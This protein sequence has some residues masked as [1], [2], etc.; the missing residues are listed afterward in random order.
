MNSQASQ[1]A[2]LRR[3]RR[4]CPYLTRNG[5]LG[6]RC[7]RGHSNSSSGVRYAT[8]FDSPSQVRNTCTLACS[9]LLSRA[10]ALGLHIT[11]SINKLT[12]I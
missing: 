11:T 5:S 1:I 6:Y 9:S 8:S 2:S 7:N 12:T 4:Q 10:K 3:I